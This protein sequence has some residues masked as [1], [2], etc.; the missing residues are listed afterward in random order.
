MKTIFRG[1]NF[2]SS[3]AAFGAATKQRPVKIK[4]FIGGYRYFFSGGCLKLVASEDISSEIIFASGFLSRASSE[5]IF[6]GSCVMPTAS[7]NNFP[8]K[9]INP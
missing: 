7:K 8:R 4:I 6:A 1:G 2:R 5:I 9:K 3:L